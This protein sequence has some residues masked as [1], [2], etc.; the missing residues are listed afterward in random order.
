MLMDQQAAWARAPREGSRAY[1]AFCHHRDLGV[2]RSVAKAWTAHQTQ[3]LHLTPA[4]RRRASKRWEVWC[5]LW[6]WPQRSEAW[7]LDV[8]R[9][10]R[11][12]AVKELIDARLRHLRIVQA[13]QQAASVSARVVLEVAQDPSQIAKL[14]REARDSSRLLLD[15]LDRASRNAHAAVA[16]V[17][18]ERLIL[19]LSTSSVEVDDTRRPRSIGDTIPSNPRMTELAIELLALYDADRVSNPEVRAQAPGAVART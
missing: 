9:Q 14:V 5:A 6:A 8:E 12:K 3:C 17:E 4:P 19:G 15:H 11:E 7:D 13:Q 1:H 18:C 16:L 10:T 2:G